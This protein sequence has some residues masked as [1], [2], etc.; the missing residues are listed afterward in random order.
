MFALLSP[1]LRNGRAALLLVV[2]ALLSPGR[3]E[4]RCGHPNAVFKANLIAVEKSEPPADQSVQ[5][6]ERPAPAAP[7]PC[8]GP[9][10]SGV[11][12]RDAPPTVAPVTP[13][14]TE[15]TLGATHTHHP[16]DAR[17]KFARDGSSAHP[18]DHPASIFHPPR[19]V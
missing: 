5:A 14:A 16:S 3:A 8:H 17:P 1:L 2:V 10:C 19:S 12:T 6:S 15:A 7:C 4:A 11:P 18:I 9:N 13:Q